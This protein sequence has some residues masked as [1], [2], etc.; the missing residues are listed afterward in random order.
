LPLITDCSG[1]DKLD[2]WNERLIQLM[3]VSDAEW[4]L[5]APDYLQPILHYQAELC[6][7]MSQSVTW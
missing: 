6:H 5:V 2:V 7:E 1:R 4:A 3:S